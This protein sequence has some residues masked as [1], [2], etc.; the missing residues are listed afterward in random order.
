LAFIASLGTREAIAFGEGVALPTRFRFAN[1]PKELLP[2]SESGIKAQLD[3]SAAVGAEFI[4]AVVE[5]WREATTTNA[6]PKNGVVGEPDA[7]DLENAFGSLDAFVPKEPA[8]V[9]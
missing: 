6:R 9:R 7:A 2:K 5:R 1:V 8:R 3:A 4:E